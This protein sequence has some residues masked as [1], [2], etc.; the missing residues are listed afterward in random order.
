[1]HTMNIHEAKSHLSK[2]IELAFEG[3]EVVICKAGKPMVQLVRYQENNHPRTPGYW[4]GKVHI[5][6]DFDE[7]PPHLTAAFRGDIH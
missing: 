2:L 4:K 7:L 5:S 6:D 3:E 1:M